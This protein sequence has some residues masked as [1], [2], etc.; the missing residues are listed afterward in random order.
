MEMT[1]ADAKTGR[2]KKRR[3]WG[4]GNPH[5]TAGFLHARKRRR[6]KK[7]GARVRLETIRRADGTRRD[8]Q[9]SFCGAG[10]GTEE[11]KK[12]IEKGHKK[13]R[14]AGRHAYVSRSVAAW[15]ERAVIFRRVRRGYFPGTPLR[16]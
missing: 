5:A 10:F 15:D 3:G 7:A 14:Q 6:A 1:G 11:Q 2:A 9:A 13:P 4:A 12:R 16:S 8:F